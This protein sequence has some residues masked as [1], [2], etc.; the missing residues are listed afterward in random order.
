M[1]AAAER[2]RYA[3]NPRWECERNLIGSRSQIF[4]SAIAHSCRDEGRDRLLKLKCRDEVAPR[5]D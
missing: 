2:N 4:S 3:A 5:S 1:L